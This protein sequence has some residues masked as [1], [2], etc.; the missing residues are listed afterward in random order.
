MVVNMNTE[1]A[2]LQFMT[3]CGLVAVTNDWG[4]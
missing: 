3:L 2:A 4:L 1:I